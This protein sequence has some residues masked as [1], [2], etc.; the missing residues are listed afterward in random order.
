MGDLVQSVEQFARERPVALLSG[1]MVAGFALA[2]FMKSSSA[3]RD[4]RVDRSDEPR[5]APA[6][7]PAGD[8]TTPGVWTPDTTAPSAGG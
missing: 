3:R 7:T 1:A 5:P 2:R 6:A 8:T 4:R